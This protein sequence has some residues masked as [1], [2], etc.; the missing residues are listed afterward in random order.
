MLMHVA[1]YDSFIFTVMQLYSIIC[2]YY[3]LFIFFCA[4]V[5]MG[6]FHFFPVVHSAPRKCVRCMGKNFS[7]VRVCY[8][9]E[10]FIY[11]CIYIYRRESAGLQGM[12]SSPLLGNAKLFHQ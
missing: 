12:H 3:H 5:H 6:C 2:I 10:I 9:Q 7:R 11:I 1:I 4:N 8:L